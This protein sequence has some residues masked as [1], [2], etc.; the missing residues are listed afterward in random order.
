[1]CV[2]VLKELMVSVCYLDKKR[3]SKQCL[4]V[5]TAMRRIIDQQNSLHTEETRED[6][7]N[8][9]NEDNEEG[10]DDEQWYKNCTRVV[11]SGENENMGLIT[12]MISVFISSDGRLEDSLELVVVVLNLMI[13]KTDLSCCC[14]LKKKRLWRSLGQEHWASVA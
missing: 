1:M 10:I 12:L 3:R 14:L 11:E 5:M 2:C 9:D 6:E 4:E 13:E 8:T 7:D